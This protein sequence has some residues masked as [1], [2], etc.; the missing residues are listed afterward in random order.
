MH[1]QIALGLAASVLLVFWM[2][3]QRKRENLCPCG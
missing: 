1:S 2:Y 3:T